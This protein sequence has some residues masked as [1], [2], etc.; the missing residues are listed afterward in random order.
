MKLYA[1]RVFVNDWDRAC[2][3]YEHTLGLPI[4]FK[5]ASMGWAE[6]DVGGGRAWRSSVSARTTWKDVPWLDDSWAF[7][8]RLKTS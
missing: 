7:P 1:L 2:E 3:F 5:D 4:K 8:C 6:F